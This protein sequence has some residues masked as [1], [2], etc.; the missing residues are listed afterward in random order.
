[1]FVYLHALEA[2]LK[3]PRGSQ[4]EEDKTNDTKGMGKWGQAGPTG[5]AQRA[6]LSKGFMGA[7][8]I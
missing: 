6:A 8:G 5:N 4:P 3:S 1:M 7:A 2:E